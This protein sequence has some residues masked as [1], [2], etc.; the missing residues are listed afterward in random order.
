MP[1][2]IDFL[3]NTRQVEKAAGDIESTMAK[4]GQSLDDVGRQGA[5]A[6]DELADGIADGAA[7]A[8]SDV[9]K[10][11]RSFADLAREARD[12]SRKAGDSLKR[13]IKDGADDAK[14]AVGE[15]G[16][17][18]GSTGREMAA[19]FKEPADALDAVQE[20]AANALAPL[21]PAGMVAGA[22][23][24]VGIGLATTAVEGF[25]EQQELSKERAAEWAAAYVEAGG[26]V[27]GAAQT[28]ARALEIVTNP[29]RYK[30]AQDNARE[31]GVTESIALLAMS[32]NTDALAE[33][34]RKL[35]E[36]KIEL[37]DQAEDESI[38]KTS[39]KYLQLVNDVRN[40]EEALSGLKGEMALGKSAADVYSESLRLTAENTHGATVA[41]DDFG[42]R[43]YTL[44]DGKQ[45]YIDAETKKATESADAIDRK[46]YSINGYKK[47]TFDAD[48]SEV[49]RRIEALNG[50]TVHLRLRGMG[51]DGWNS[52]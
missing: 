17:E 31:W 23:V 35:A 13:E 15:M 6:G 42:D 22:A 11:E 39:E 14:K 19:S 26:T 4:V 2:K 30:E 5:K 36:R 44:P 7:D 1:I 3:A 49:D 52:F 41:V 50:R 48:T 29:E 34:S 45:I 27:L 18:A 28:T 24:A 51:A 12:E 32:G 43:I 33:A 10:L 47:I 25:N 21:G 40:G 9:D 38:S 37:R 8:R 20:L 16:E 46:I